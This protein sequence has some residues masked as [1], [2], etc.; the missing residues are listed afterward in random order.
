MPLTGSILR[1]SPHIANSKLLLLLGA[2]SKVSKAIIKEYL[3]TFDFSKL[4]PVLALRY[5]L[6]TFLLSG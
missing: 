1:Y 3:R 6:S 4:H 2:D 5:F